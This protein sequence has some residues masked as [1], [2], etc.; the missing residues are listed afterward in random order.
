[1][2]HREDG[3]A[4]PGRPSV[5]GALLPALV[6]GFGLEA[7]RTGLTLLSARPAGVHATLWS[8][9]PLVVAAL[10]TA[11]VRWVRPPRLTM[12]HAS[13]LAVLR[14]VVAVVGPGAAAV[15]A[16]GG[17]AL[18]AAWLM[19][20]PATV[21]SPRQ[22]VRAVVVAQAVLVLERW[23][24]GSL[25]LVWRHDL[26]SFVWTLGGCALLLVLAPLQRSPVR[27]WRELPL[28]LALP[29][30]LLMELVFLANPPRVAEEL[31]WGTGPAASFLG[32]VTVAGGLLTLGG[33]GLL[34]GIAARKLRSRWTQFGYHAVR[35]GAGVLW[36]A[37]LSFGALRLAAV[38]AG[39][40]AVGLSTGAL[41]RSRPVGIH[42]ANGRWGVLL[43][44]LL[45]GMMSR[46]M[47]EFAIAAS[48]LFH[49]DRPP[50]GGE[51]ALRWPLAAL[52]ALLWVAT[53][54]IWWPRGLSERKLTADGLR[55]AVVA[56]IPD[57]AAGMRRLVMAGRALQRAHP[58]LVVLQGDV[59][60]G[61][62]LCDPAWHLAGRLRLPLVRS[63]R[64]PAALLA[65]R[66]AAFE[67]TRSGVAAASWKLGEG[68]FAVAAAP[69][70]LT[71]ARLAEACRVVEDVPR[72]MVVSGPRAGDV[73]GSWPPV[74]YELLPGDE[75]GVV[76][77]SQGVNVAAE[78]EHG[79]P[80]V[81]A[82]L[83]EVKP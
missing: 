39:P 23:L 70:E 14:A 49:L 4:E 9:L 51:P 1:M 63:R 62:L 22:A 80:G 35:L 79:T 56:A 42:R 25:D 10:L 55:V 8:L 75:R 11:P 57:G 68:G 59:R 76:L 40:L 65:P 48:A 34:R 50:E 16:V 13:L 6:M 2:A 45:A 20:W 18:A 46:H 33:D 24:T 67:V 58:Q 21:E 72:R 43:A 26:T 38:A 52:A 19:L 66:P 31:G 47:G 44:W 83:L 61:V 15:W 77:L 29:F 30:I 54:G 5:A 28:A 73:A 64:T 74:G 17:M 81:R 78:A 69:G 53:V 7:W 82:L 36:V 27:P 32:L 41:L 60:R 3:A 71:A 37:G 12:L